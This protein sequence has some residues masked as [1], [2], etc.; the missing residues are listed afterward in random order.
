[1]E[2]A[3]LTLRPSKEIIEL[4][5]KLAMEEKTSIT[6]MFTGFILSL[7]RQKS[8][9]SSGGGYKGSGIGP[10]TKSLSGIVTLPEEFDE[11]EFMSY[12]F[13]EKYGLGK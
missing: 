6:Q 7:H 12:F 9:K 8:R 4:A 2:T 5:H 13:T 3:K 10:L 11:K 1:M